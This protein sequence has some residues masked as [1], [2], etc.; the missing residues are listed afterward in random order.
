MKAVVLVCALAILVPGLCLAQAPAG[1]IAGVVRDPSS[2]VVPEA[3]V[4]A[5]S[6]ATGEVRQTITSEHGEY[7][8]PAL[9]AGE[10]EVSVA[11]SGFQR[12]VRVARTEA[13][14]TTTADLT[15]QVG[16]LADSIN[17]DAALPRI[18]YDSAAVGGVI[19]RDLIERVPLNGRSFLELSKLEP[20]LQ[21]PTSTNRNRTIVPVLGAP[22]SN[23]GGPRFTVDGGSVSSVG[24][25]G[26]QMGFS[27]EVVQEFQ[28]ATVNFDPSAGLSA[29]G[30]V[31]VVTRAG[32][33]DFQGTAFYFLRDH[34]LAAYPA[35]NRDH[36]NSDPAFQRQ[37]F[38]LAM[39]GPIREGRI[40]AFGSWERNDQRAVT[41][42]TLLIPDFAHLSGITQTPLLGDLASVRVDAN[43]TSAHRA[44]ARYS[45]DRSQAFGPG[46]AIGPLN[47]YPSS[48]SRAAIGADQAL[49]GLTSVLRPTW[50]SDLRF[51]YFGISSS[52][53]P[54]RERDCRDCL[55]LGAPLISIPEAGL[56]IGNSSAVDYLGDRF[57]L[58]ESVTWQ[59]NAHRWRVGVDW[60]HNSER[61]FLWRNDPAT[62]VLFSPD[63]VRAYNT[64]PDL[65]AEQRIPLPAAFHTVD[66]L[67]QLPLQSL[68]IG[69]GEPGV[70]QENG[71]DL[72]R[73]NTLWLHAQDTWRTHETLTLS[74]GVGWGFD[75][76][77]NDDLEKPPLLAPLFGTDGLGPTRRVWTNVSP[78]FGLAW[79]PASDTRTV[80]RAGAGRYYGTHGL[81][82]SM[83]AERVALGPPGLQQ[84]FAG[85]SIL[86]ST[87]GIPGVAVGRPLNFR[88]APTRFTGAH[89]MAVLAAIRAGLAER[90]AIADP[91]VQQIQVSKQAS[92]AIF[93]VDVPSPSAVHMNAGLQRDVGQGVVLSADLVYRH[94]VHVPQGGGSFDLNHFDSVRGPVIPEC[95]AAQR[96]DP[97]ALCSLGPINVQMAPFRFAYKGLLLRADA[98][99]PH[100]VRVLGS[101]AYSSNTGT[102]IGNGFN[103]ENWLENRGPAPNDFT[104]LLNVAGDT[105]LPWGFQVGF[106]FAYASAPPFSA[107]VGGIDFNGDGTA[108]DLLPGTTVNAF[109]RGMGRADLERLVDQFNQ[110]HAGEADTQGAVIPRLTLPPRYS[111]GDNVHGLDLRL[112]HSFAISPGLRLVVI[113]EVFNVYNAANLSGHSGDLASAAFGQPVSRAPQAF[114]SSGPRA[115]QVATRVSF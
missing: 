63:A 13:G 112:S 19:T 61:N 79:T 97:Q 51:S 87:P 49:L 30:A 84:D 25:G 55:G 65:A 27:Q 35:L 92:P 75:G 107:Y 114:G 78:T 110:T 26:S 83:D 111:F 93:P 94:F 82:S 21:S 73:W 113:G 44:F 81:T 90:L 1:T 101:Y 28:V 103:L 58:S 16:D 108:G 50:V 53:G 64:R 77:L 9:L 47:A 71:G 105:Q 74:Y 10:Y 57:H 96:D 6:R 37:Q 102:N 54:G 109:N 12:L 89:M 22:A 59:G 39:G 20:G 85:T 100:A 46:T 2:A 36:D 42:T 31:N 15:L 41:A 40:F 45:H 67:L 38:G 17:V 18:R 95:S 5:I 62:I 24:F 14:T 91:T 7:S 11:P 99:L 68:T 56:R 33:N 106:N 34:R 32:S 60:E 48:W 70:P 4:Q 29:A 88:G 86:N 80:I 8:F 3:R 76:V 115:F 43:I 23:V 66:D 72:R 104:H 52:I 69:V 98:R